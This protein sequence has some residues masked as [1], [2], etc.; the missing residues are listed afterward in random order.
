MFEKKTYFIMIKF[1]D[2]ARWV[3]LQAGAAEKLV[4]CHASFACRLER[5]HL[6]S[7]VRCSE[8]ETAVNG[9]YLAVV[10]GGIG[11]IGYLGL[12]NFCGH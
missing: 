10:S 7:S 8:V 1:S 12:E 11:G 9:V 3:I 4:G 2:M 6:D 5:E